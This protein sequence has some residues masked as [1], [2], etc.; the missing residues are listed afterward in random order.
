MSASLAERDGADEARFQRYRQAMA[1][2]QLVD[3]LR[4]LGL[5]EGDTVM[6]HA[7]LRRVGPVEGGAEGLLAAIEAVVGPGG[8]ILMVLGAA[9]PMAWVNDRP[10]HERAALLAGSEP[11]DHLTTPADPD[12]G[13][14]AELFRVRPGT[15]VSDH[16]EGRFAAAGRL[17]RDLT[18]DIP[19]DDYFGPGSPLDRLVAARGKVLRLGADPGTVTLIHYPEYLDDLATKRR[20]RR[21]R[22]VREATGPELRI[23]DSLDDSNGIVDVEGEDYFETI[24]AAYLATGRASTGRVRDAASELIDAADLVAFAVDW[25]AEHLEPLAR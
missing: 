12:V 16:P 7:S 17:A 15:L 25:M 4:S 9:D 14:L 24:L 21:Y 5:A 8:T 18:E 23:V 19:W 2:A 6:V 10:E 22:R 3:D 20:V 1:P 11:F 13:A